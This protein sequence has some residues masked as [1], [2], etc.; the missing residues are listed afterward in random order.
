[1]E[2]DYVTRAHVR[3]VPLSLV[4][5]RLVL[6]HPPS[7]MTVRCTREQEEEEEEEQEVAVESE[8]R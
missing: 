2:P 1:M 3:L 7:R 8:S 6:S 5:S 4:L